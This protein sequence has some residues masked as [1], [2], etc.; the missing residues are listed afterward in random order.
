MGKK[1][2]LARLREPSTW[3]GMAAIGVAFGVGL[4]PGMV[5]AVTQI[6]VGVAGLLGI[7]MKEGSK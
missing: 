7:F 2:I 1:F 6:G 3:S 5:E 4:P